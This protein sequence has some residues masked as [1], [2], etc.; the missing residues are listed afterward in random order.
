MNQA[1]FN[2]NID[3]GGDAN[4]IRHSSLD[5]VPTV[6]PDGQPAMFETLLTSL[7]LIDVCGPDTRVFL[8]NLLTNDVEHLQLDEV[9]LGGL[10]SPKGRLLA[11][12][13]YWALPQD[14]G[15][16]LMLSADLAALIAQRLSMFV[17]RS[18]VKIIVQTE[19][20]LAG[21]IATQT[22]LAKRFEDLPG[23]AFLC[24]KRADDST[25]LRLSNVM[26]FARV[27][28]LAPSQNIEA[29]LSNPAADNARRAAQYWD[30]LEVRSG[31]PRL[32]AAS[33]DKFVP[34]MINFEVV[35]GVSFKKGCYP[36]QEVVARSQYRGTIK[37]RLHLAHFEAEQAHAP[38][39][40]PHV[41]AALFHSEDPTQPCGEI[42]NAAPAPTGG[43]DCLVELKLA[44]LGSG[45]IH[46]GSPN[47][48]L[49]R[50]GQLPYELPS[51]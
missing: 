8:H 23:S 5:A 18:K 36:G 15:V 22:E 31:E 6:M 42:V 13:H 28:L 39:P 19:L 3:Y 26:G 44:A 45:T 24:A 46:V 33:V 1:I 7:A 29:L 12:L 51:L 38:P 2:A 43:V 48:A 50:T 17:L 41:G 9:R 27:I 25:L 40:A 47:G 11:T 49:L 14:T 37:R 20:T 4:P 30:W 21:F 10:C 34:Q 35:K 32:T 16:R